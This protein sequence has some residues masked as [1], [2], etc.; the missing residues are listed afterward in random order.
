[1]PTVNKIPDHS[2]QASKGVKLA[3]IVILPGNTSLQDRFG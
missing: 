3:S 2:I 1:M